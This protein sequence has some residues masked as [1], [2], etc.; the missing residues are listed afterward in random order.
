L[1]NLLVRRSSEM[2]VVRKEKKLLGEASRVSEKTM[3]HA[4][5]M[6]MR[7]GMQSLCILKNN[8]V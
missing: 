5:S 4:E 7:I 2:A 8:S 3:G 1:I 6:R